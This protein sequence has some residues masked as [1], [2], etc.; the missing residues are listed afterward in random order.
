MP[1]PRVRYQIFISSTY[2][3]LKLER[4]SAVEAILRAGHI[5]AGMELFAAQN[6]PQMDVI[7][8]WIEES[9][10]F[11]LI[12]GHRY[13][14]I[15]PISQRSYIECEY[16]HALALGKPMFSIVMHDDWINEKVKEEGYKNVLEQENEQL[17][18]AFRD[19]ITSTLVR[20]ARTGDEIKLAVFESIG[21]LERQFE[22]EGWVRAKDARMPPSIGEELA[23][24]SA[25][26]ARLTRELAR[27]ASQRTELIQGK[28][29]QEWIR[30]LS[31]YSVKTWNAQVGTISDQDTVDLSIVLLNYGHQLGA[32]VDNSVR[33]KG[34]E[35][36]LFNVAKVLASHGLAETKKTPAG[37]H[38][39]RLGLTDSGKS[40]YTT[41][42]GFALKKPSEVPQEQSDPSPPTPDDSTSAPKGEKRSPPKKASKKSG[43]QKK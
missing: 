20:I 23:R 34:F 27:A 38:W 3:D 22:V 1:K 16:D 13:G 11:C 33:A 17:M 5:P 9:D 35:M 28:T 42:R 36:W 37:V 15:E 39:Q 18:R 26:N 6:K 30:I 31:S 10:I 12:L 29:V 40:L 32:G 41:L 8:E 21:A 14:S 19:R 4:Q 7:R 2:K 25:E 24:L 43:R